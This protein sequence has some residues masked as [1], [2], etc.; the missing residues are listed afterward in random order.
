MNPDS[1][2]DHRKEL[3]LLQARMFAFPEEDWTR[4]RARVAELKA[5]IAEQEREEE[6]A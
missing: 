3:R 1:L 5:L 4:E 2:E 6:D